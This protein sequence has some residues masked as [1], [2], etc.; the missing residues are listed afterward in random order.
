MFSYDTIILTYFI[1]KNRTCKQVYQIYL[2]IQDPHH[3]AGIDQNVVPF[4]QVQFIKEVPEN[5]KSEQEKLEKWEQG[6]IKDDG[7]NYSRF[8]K[9]IDQHDN[10]K[11]KNNRFKDCIGK[12]AFLPEQEICGTVKFLG[13]P[14]GGSKLLCGI[15]TV[16]FSVLLHGCNFGK[17]ILTFLTVM[18]FC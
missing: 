15:E 3:A 5:I 6:G 2:S 16:T 11:E 12:R 14:E 13:K 8:P 10:E 9:E 4:N 18:S 7:K 1:S 17:D